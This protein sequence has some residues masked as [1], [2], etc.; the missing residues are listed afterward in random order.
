MYGRLSEPWNLAMLTSVGKA[1][2]GGVD[3][4]HAH[5]GLIYARQ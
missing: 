1:L 4:I 2:M 3:S 5:L